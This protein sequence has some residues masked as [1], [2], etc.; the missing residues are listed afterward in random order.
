M[1]DQ[2]S[3]LTPR[4]A[5]LWGLFCVAISAVPILGGFGV[6]DLKPEPG[7]PRWICVAAGGLFFLA[8]LSLIVDGASGAIGPDGQIR[9][10][11]PPW[12]HVF[13]SLIGL[14]IVGTMG[15]VMSWIAFGPG[16]RHFSSTVSL[17][18]GSWHPASSDTTGRWAFGIAAVLIW[19]IMAGVIVVSVRRLIA[20]ARLLASGQV[21]R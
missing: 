14:G 3:K 7:T 2:Q 1:A 21:E 20:R 4:S 12:F 5:I 18:F 15:A 19:C 11:G 10:D 6:I 9:T 13:Q 16:E 17:P 8:G